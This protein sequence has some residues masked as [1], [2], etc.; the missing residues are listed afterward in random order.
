MSI[1]R[2]LFLLRYEKN[3]HATQEVPFFPAMQQSEVVSN[4]GS[5]NVLDTPPLPTN[6]SEGDLFTTTKPIRKASKP[7]KYYQWANWEWDRLNNHFVSQIQDQDISEVGTKGPLPSKVA[8]TAFLKENNILEFLS[9][10]EKIKVIKTKI[11][12]ERTK[13][14]RKFQCDNKI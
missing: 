11:F 7:R 3:K 8:I 12:N 10:A 1:R 14:R 5:D 13:F 4:S 6:N 9:E 2:I